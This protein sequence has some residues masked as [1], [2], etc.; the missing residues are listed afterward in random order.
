MA[1]FDWI[2][3]DHDLRLDGKGVRLR[4]HRAADYTEWAELRVEIGDVVG[5]FGVRIV[6]LPVDDRIRIGIAVL[7]RDTRAFAERHFPVAIE[8]AARVDADRER[9]DLGVAAPAAGEKIAQ[10]RLNRRM[11]LPVPVDA[12]NKIAPA[13]VGRRDPD[14][15]D[16]PG[17][18][19]FAEREGLAR[20]DP[21]R[22]RDLPT[23]AESA[24]VNGAGPL[25]RHAAL[26]FF[27]GEVFRADRA[28]FRVR[29]ARQIAEIHAE[30]RET[31]HALPYLM[32]LVLMDS[33][34][35]RWNTT[36]IAIVGTATTVEAAMM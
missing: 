21:H 7:Q 28:R 15:L 24:R 31:A 11:L 12:K 5:H 9:T 35:W 29:Q 6:D 34:I 36:N 25:L 20:R 16:R 23:A 17:A 26:A 33:M 8:G 3:P 1:L 19:D 2:S 13:H 18:L 27:A 32:P 30:T 4:P 22:G 10:R 14:L